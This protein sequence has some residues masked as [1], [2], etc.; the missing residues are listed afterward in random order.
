MLNVK[1]RKYRVNSA[2]KI[3]YSLLA[4]LFL[5]LMAGCATSSATPPAANAGEPGYQEHP[6]SNLAEK[7][8]VF[9]FHR[10]Q[11]CSKCLY[12]EE[13]SRYTVETYFKNELASGKVTFKV[14]NVQ[15]EENAVIVKKYK[16]YT[17]SLFINTIKDGTD[18]IKEATD[19]YSLIGNDDAFVKAVKSTIE[20]SLKGLI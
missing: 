19:V 1:D 15:D 7:I 14:F 4:C 2:I 16:A 18:H 11:R 5:C 6:G 13:H 8:E 3:L 10:T 20:Q 9:Y 17:S 12:V